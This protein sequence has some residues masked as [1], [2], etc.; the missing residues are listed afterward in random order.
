[1]ADN[2]N[3][4][5]L[6]IKKIEE[7]PNRIIIDSSG[8]KV[9]VNKPLEGTGSNQGTIDIDLS[10]YIKTKEQLEG[11]TIVTTPEPS[12]TSAGGGMTTYLEIG[13]AVAATIIVAAVIKFVIF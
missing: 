4:D 13:A 10:S 8:Q 2:I 1:M 3:I 9:I 7:V 12:K 6:P 11:K 5:G